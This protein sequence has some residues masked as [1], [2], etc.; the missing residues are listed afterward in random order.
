VDIQL[1]G[2]AAAYLVV[3]IAKYAITKL[4]PKPKAGLSD[5][6]KQQLHDLWNWHNK[7]DDSGRP[8]WY[9][10]SDIGDQQDKMLD[11]MRDVSNNQREQARQMKEVAKI[12]E[13]ILDKLDS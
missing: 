6:E 1:A 3:E 8:L 7:T 11:V 10:P 12:L 2:L 9:M 4:A 13:K 5:T